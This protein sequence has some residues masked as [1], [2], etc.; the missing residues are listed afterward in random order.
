MPAITWILQNNMVSPMTSKVAWALRLH[1]YPFLDCS[2]LDCGDALFSCVE[3][4]QG[5]PYFYYGSTGGFRMLVERYGVTS[6]V[7]TNPSTLDSRTWSNHLAHN[8]LNPHPEIMPLHAFEERIQSGQIRDAFV[9]PVVEQKAFTGCVIQADADGVINTNGI[10]IDRFLHRKNHDPQMLLAVSPVVSS[11]IVAE[12]RCVSL[13]GHV[14]LM[15]RY[16]KDGRLSVLGEV[17][18]GVVVF[19]DNVLKAWHPDRAM[20]VDVALLANGEYRIVEFNGL[21]SSGLYAID[22]WEYVKL[23]NTVGQLRM[24]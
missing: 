11:P 8:L 9:R 13:D 14:E 18:P 19:V 15:S 7:Y 6:N 24:A 10:W 22:P 12:W 2:V 16:K 3:A 1:D 21:H 5:S 17:V 20:I 4:L 23:I